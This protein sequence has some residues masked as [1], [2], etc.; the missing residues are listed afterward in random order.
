M[1]RQGQDFHFDKRLFEISEF[2][3]TRVNCIYLNTLL[4]H[5][6]ENVANWLTNTIRH[7]FAMIAKCSPDIRK[8]S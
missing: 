1:F 2:E 7:Q 3:I 6:G 5:L 8:C 4:S